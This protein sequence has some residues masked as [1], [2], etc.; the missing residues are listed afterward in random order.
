MH[1]ATKAAATLT[2]L[3]VCSNTYAVTGLDRLVFSP[4]FMFEKGNFVELTLARSD[5]AVSPEFAP[6]ANVA[7]GVNT[8][9]LS[10]KHQINDKFGLG[11]MV[12]TQPIGADVNYQAVGSTL[13]GSVSSN[14]Y[15]ALG[16]YKATDRISAFG[17]IKYQTAKG[18]AD[19]RSLNATIPGATSFT[20]DSDTGLILGAAYSIP[21]IALRASLSY[22]SALGFDLDSTVPALGDLS[23]GNTTAG[24][25]KTWL[26][27]LQSGIAKDTLLFGS[28]RRTNWADHQ[29]M[30]L[31]NT[32]LSTF[33]NKTDYKLGIG[34]KFSDSISGSITLNYEPSDGEP[35]SP[36][37][38]QD[39]EKGV[40]VGLKFKAKDGFTTTVGIQ[41]RK[42]GDTVT[43]A[44][45]GSLP[46][47][48]N[49]VVTAGLKFS[50]NF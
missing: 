39:G 10:Y 8:L 33:T 41:Y 2:T 44:S 25:P 34:R 19:L 22:E 21:K 3:L 27:E 24:T 15:I 1:N 49:D 13:K 18:E 30:F 32:Q 46:F 42:L 23:L 17:G 5:P 47:K 31:E 28:I 35:S 4:S 7:E 14:S 6:D 36:F 9:R 40:T 26:L 37:A 48:D 50:K 29:I 16:H 20:E 11:L 38:P 45:S 43:T 12:N